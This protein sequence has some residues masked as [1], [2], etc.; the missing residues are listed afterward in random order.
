MASFKIHYDTRFGQSVCLAG[1]IPELGNWTEFKY[2]MVWTEG[3]Y[4][5]ANDIEL[6]CGV[7][8]YKYVIV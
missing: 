5:V 1:G 6:S 4:W 8:E 7:F 2:E 3:N